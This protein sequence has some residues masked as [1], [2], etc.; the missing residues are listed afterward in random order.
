MIAV[1]TNRTWSEFIWPEWVPTKLRAQI[2]DFW[3]DG[4]SRGPDEWIKNT[5]CPYNGGHDLGTLVQRRNGTSFRCGRYVHRW[6][7]MASVVFSDGTSEVVAAQRCVATT[8]AEVAPRPD[9]KEA[10]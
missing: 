9:E 7:N 4:W 3:R 6:N 5:H 2:E 10:T 1:A 8:S